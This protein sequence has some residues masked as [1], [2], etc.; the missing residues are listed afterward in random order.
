VSAAGVVIAR[1]ETR[2]PATLLGQR[3]EVYA[4]RRQELMKRIAEL[5]GPGRSDESVI[6]LRGVDDPELAEGRFRQS[7]DF[8]YLTGAEVPGAWLILLPKQQKA[9]LYLPPT[10]TG[11]ERMEG[12]RP[13]PG[14]ETAKAL[15]IENV[16]STE[17]LLGD[18]FG[19]I[20]DPQK[21]GPNR[22]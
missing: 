17:R 13:G 14:P 3:K 18:L 12:P 2:E 22:G 11:I 6:V 15:G 16:E 7:N 1:D 10:G 4:E 20:A 21:M 9:T 19:A 5:R 8:A